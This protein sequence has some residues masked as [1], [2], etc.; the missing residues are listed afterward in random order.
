MRL[1][2]T[3]DP[4]CYP[5]GHYELELRC[6]DI[7][8]RRRREA[9]VREAKIVADREAKEAAARKAQAEAD[10]RTREEAE[11]KAREEAEAGPVTDVE[12]DDDRRVAEV[13]RQFPLFRF[14]SRREVL[15]AYAE[16]P[17]K[18]LKTSEAP[19]TPEPESKPK[20]KAK[21]RSRAKERG[22]SD[23]PR[24]REKVNPKGVNLGKGMIAVNG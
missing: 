16:L 17:L 8:S 3:S 4:S 1:A 18:T 20:W 10:R 9:E 23:E 14:L 7:E 11:R 6:Q 12:M 24:V 5:E 2:R 13:H 15:N 21:P 22:V 19:E